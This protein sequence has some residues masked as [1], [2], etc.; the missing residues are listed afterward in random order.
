MTYE[1]VMDVACVAAILVAW[2]VWLYAAIWYGC[3]F[4]YWLTDY[5]D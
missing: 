4:L 1:I 2:V 5:D 3:K